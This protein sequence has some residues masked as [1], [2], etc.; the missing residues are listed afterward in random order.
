MAQ[1]GN[2]ESLLVD[3]QATA[4]LEP[5]QPKAVQR[6]EPPADGDIDELALFERFATNQN[7]DLDRLDRLMTMARQARKERQEMAFNAALSRAAKNIRAAVT[8]EYNDQTKSWF[9]TH[10]ALDAVARPHYTAE[11]LTLTFK[12][13][14]STIT[15]YITVVCLVKHEAGWTERYELD[16]P[17]DG[18]GAKGGDVMTKTHAT[19]S[20]ITYAM[21]YLLKMV[22][23]IPIKDKSDD[24]GVEAGKD[25]S[26]RPPAPAKFD[27]WWAEMQAVAA[28]GIDA[29]DRA[30]QNTRNGALKQYA[31]DHMKNE[32]NALKRQASG[33]S[34]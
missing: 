11:G 22:F 4:A 2:T 18:K 24:D 5:S 9:A 14:R 15:D 26:K 30:W 28:E 7:I 31:L 6:M 3:E 10:E 34:R 33:V 19:G 29:F 13:E 27:E 1:K 12:P 20:A 8:N 23:N 17:A 25:R 21:R 32:Y 16:M